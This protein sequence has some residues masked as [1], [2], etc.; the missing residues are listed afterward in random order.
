RSTT[1][2]VVSQIAVPREVGLHGQS[3]RITLRE[4]NLQRVVRGSSL[5]PDQ[6]RSGILRTRD[7]KVL[8]QVRSEQEI[9]WQCTAEIRLIDEAGKPSGVVVCEETQQRCIPGENVLRAGQGRVDA[10]ENLV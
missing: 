4:F 8:R 5:I 6:K 10:A 9:A 7:Y 1:S 3:S 2:I